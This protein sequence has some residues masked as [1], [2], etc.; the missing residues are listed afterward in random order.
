MVEEVVDLHFPDVDE[1]EFEEIVN[2]TVNES[3]QTL[4]DSE[5]VKKF[6]KYFP[7]EFEL[8]GGAITSPKAYNEELFPLGYVMDDQRHLF[9]AGQFKDK[10][11]HYIKGPDQKMRLYFP[12]FIKEI[13]LKTLN[14]KELNFGEIITTDDKI[15][16]PEKSIAIQYSS[17]I[18]DL[19]LN[20]NTKKDAENFRAKFYFSPTMFGFCQTNIEDIYSMLYKYERYACNHVLYKNPHPAEKIKQP[21]LKTAFFNQD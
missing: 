7:T 14:D 16:A 9:L 5:Q 17:I 12:E 10:L 21:G 6:Q 2:K 20:P 4:L 13:A 18:H 8:L 15:I 1:K 19:P 3:E 11:F